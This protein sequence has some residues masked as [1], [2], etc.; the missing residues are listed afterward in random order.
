M[1]KKPAG[2]GIRLKCEPQ[3]KTG[4]DF[5]NDTIYLFAQSYFLGDG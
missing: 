3:T 5:N 2:A 4:T 1:S